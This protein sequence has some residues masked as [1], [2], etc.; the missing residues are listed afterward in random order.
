VEGDRKEKNIH[1]IAFSSFGR[2]ISGGDRIWIEFA[3]HWAQKKIVEVVTWTE[4]KAMYDRQNKPRAPHLYFNIQKNIFFSSKNFLLSYILRIIGSIVWAI[5]FSNTAIVYSASEFLMDVFPAAILK[6]KN[7]SFIW[8]ATWY[9]TA[10][11]PFRGYNNNISF[12]AFLYWFSQFITKFLIICL[13]DKV[14]VNNELEKNQFDKL[15]KSG[16]VIVVLGAVDYPLIQ[17]WQRKKKNF[18]KKYDAV[19]QGRFHPQKGVLE[20]I[21]IWEKVCKKKPNAKLVMIGDGPLFHRVQQLVIDRNLE[22]NIFLTG[23]LFDG[24]LKYQ[25]FSQSKLVVHPAMYDSG[26]MAAY[27]A[28]AFGLPVIGFALKAFSSYYPKGMVTVKIGDKNLFAYQILELLKNNRKR[29]SIAKEGQLFITSSAT[30]EI[31]SKQ[32]LQQIYL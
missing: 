30:W 9:Q 5:K 32:T 16:K 29:L 2:G 12:N 13:A 3:T 31:R 10:P 28:M 23:Y 22:A 14:L 1:I 17:K 8:I 27:E 20:L 15:N 4:G 19:F 26:G 6:L 7:P 25:Y 24:D 21:S 18:K 11:S